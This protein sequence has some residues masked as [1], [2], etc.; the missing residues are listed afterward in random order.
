MRVDHALSFIDQFAR[1]SNERS[2]GLR[3][4]SQVFRQVAQRALVRA[5]AVCSRHD[6]IATRHS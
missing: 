2:A 6:V 4:R 5:T 3:S 1:P